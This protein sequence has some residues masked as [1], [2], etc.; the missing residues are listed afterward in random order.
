MPEVVTNIAAH[1][2]EMAKR[3]PDALAVLVQGDRDEI[4]NYTYS[5]MTALQ[6]EV[7][8]N[9]VAR[10]LDR[11]GIGPGTRTVLMVTPGAEFFVLTFALFKAGAIPGDGRSWHGC[12]ESEGVSCRGGTGS[13]CRH[14]EGA[15]GAECC[16]A[17]RVRRIGPM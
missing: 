2:P 3:Q 16:S 4:G 12:Q 7:E 17:G 5:R 6:L 14:N 13:L 8:S 9:K 15:R 11:I 10:G 1:L